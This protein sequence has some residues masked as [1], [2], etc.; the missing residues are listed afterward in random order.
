MDNF[1]LEKDDDE[2]W[3]D[4]GVMELEE[5]KQRKKDPVSN[6]RICCWKKCLMGP[7]EK[8]SSPMTANAVNFVMIAFNVLALSYTMHGEWIWLCSLNIGIGMISSMLMWCVMCS[9][10]GISSRNQDTENM[11]FFKE[12]E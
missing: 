3:V 1:S 4:F 11:P 8:A 5:A 6:S 10:P 9:D 12:Q 7:K 2:D